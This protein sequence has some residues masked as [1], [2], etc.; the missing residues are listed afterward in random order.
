MSA[1]PHSEEK[2]SVGKLEDIGK[3]NALR[4][5][6]MSGM[7]KCGEALS[8]VQNE[9]LRKTIQSLEQQSSQ[10]ANELRS[11]ILVMG[12]YAPET[13]TATSTVKLSSLTVRQKVKK[14]IGS[15]L[16]ALC[17][18]MEQT[19]ISLYRNYLNEE[20]WDENMRRMIR[21]QME[22]IM[23][24]TLQLKLLSSFFHNQ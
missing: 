21:Y 17:K 18:K 13:L 15:N 14:H 3:L 1:S 10:Y 2:N 24:T 4:S 9:S 5:A 16:V 8:D 6:L 22:G 23:S 20:K 11:R 19:V 12:G 7:E